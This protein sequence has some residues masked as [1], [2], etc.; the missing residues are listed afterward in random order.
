MCDSHHQVSEILPYHCFQMT[1]YLQDVECR[2]IHAPLGWGQCGEE[3]RHDMTQRSNHLEFMQRMPGLSAAEQAAL[4]TRIVNVKRQG[5]L[6]D[7]GYAVPT[8]EHITTITDSP[9]PHFAN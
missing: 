2:F 3:T 6:T 5:V 8:T 4:C 9:P 1:H 7:W